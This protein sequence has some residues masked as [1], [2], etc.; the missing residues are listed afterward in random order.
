MV[1]PL[2]SCC[3]TGI[4]SS[5]PTLPKYSYSS[6]I[7]MVS[8]AGET[9]AQSRHPAS[10][11]S[12]P[13]LDSTKA[14]ASSGQARGGFIPSQQ[15][16]FR[17]DLKGLT[18]EIQSRIRAYRPFRGLRVFTREELESSG[19]PLSTKEVAKSLNN[20]NLGVKFC[21]FRCDLRLCCES[22]LS[23]SLLSKGCP[24]SR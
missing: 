22:C 14:S 12:K 24:F 6:K 4:L 1:P 11:L 10:I 9:V 5:V 19:P 23:P 18:H 21:A 17:K 20:K 13:A 16:F 3:R 7:L 15:V 2:Q 8:L